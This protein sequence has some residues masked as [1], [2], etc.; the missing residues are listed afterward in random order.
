[1][2]FWWERIHFALKIYSLCVFVTGWGKKNNSYGLFTGNALILL[3]FFF[4]LKILFTFR[5]RRREGERE[6]EEHRSVASHVLQP[7]TWPKIQACALTGNW[8]DNLLVR[9]MTPNPLRHTGQGRM[10]SF[11]SVSIYHSYNLF[12]S[13]SVWVIYYLLFS[14]QCARH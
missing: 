3:L 10:H 1:M 14:R 9:R 8:S 5:E 4:F 12:S 6:E 11:W 2:C 7:R 13:Q